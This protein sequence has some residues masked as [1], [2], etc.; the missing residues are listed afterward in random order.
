LSAPF[1]SVWLRRICVAENNFQR[2]SFRQLLD[3]SRRI[4]LSRQAGECALLLEA[5]SERI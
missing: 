2:S 4:L 5:I 3:F 1:A